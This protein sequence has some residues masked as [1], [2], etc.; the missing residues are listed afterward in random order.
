MLKTPLPEK[1][2]PSLLDGTHGEKG[3]AINQLIDRVEELSGVVEG[4]NCRHCEVAEQQ[5][6]THI[7]QNSL[8][9]QLLG[10]IRSLFAEASHFGGRQVQFS[11]V[12]AIINNLIP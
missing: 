8:K 5:G 1:V 11:D 4:K 3:N 2:H 6:A 7:H 9:E 10:E 12:E